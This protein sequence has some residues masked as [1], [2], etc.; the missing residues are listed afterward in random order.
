MLNA[1][2]VIRKNDKTLIHTPKYGLVELKLTQGWCKRLGLLAWRGPDLS[3]RPY[4]GTK[5]EWPKMVTDGDKSWSIGGKTKDS[6]AAS[7]QCVEINEQTNYVK[8]RRSMNTGRMAPGV[9]II[10]QSHVR[11]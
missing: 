11:L 10:T 3:A 6:V 9:L 2:L 7:E 8:K 1:R 5:D 4:S